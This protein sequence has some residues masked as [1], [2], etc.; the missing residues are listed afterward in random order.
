MLNR[1][2]YCTI[3]W[4]FMVMID[5]FYMQCS[6]SSYTQDFFFGH[7][8]VNVVIHLTPKMSNINASNKCVVLSSMSPSASL[9]R[10]PEVKYKRQHWS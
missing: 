9:Y 1:K 2:Y 3:L 7:T 6:Q 4:I 8:E 10:E 5:S